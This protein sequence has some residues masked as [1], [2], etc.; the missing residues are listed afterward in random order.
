MQDQSFDSHRLM[1]ALRDG[2]FAGEVETD[3]ALRAAMSVD[4]SVYAITP[5]LIVAPQDAADVVTLL[6]VMRQAP[7]SQ[8]P[9]TARGGGTGTNGQSLNRGV[10]VDFRRHMHRLL[11]VNVDE[12][13]AEVEPGLV[14]DD[15][16]DR[17]K[18]Y[19]LFF[20]PET[21]T[22]NRCT[23][24][25]MVATDASGKG[26][27]IYGKTSDNVAGLDVAVADGLLSST[28]PV[29]DWAG[30]ILEAAETASRAGREAFIAHTPR[31]NRRFIG[32]DLERA[33]RPDAFDW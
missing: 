27:R 23:I 8:V 29:P 31:L 16:N 11:A 28:G 2:G 15:L 30:P 26:S 19:G 3:H 5:D 14:P 18:G 17:L 9:I 6:K 33:C 21:S 4:N 20:A 7:W 25:G 32:H 13:W 22:S 10:I 24:G 12:A 1:Q